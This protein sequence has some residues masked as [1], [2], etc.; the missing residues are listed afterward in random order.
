MQPESPLFFDPTR[1]TLYAYA[2]AQDQRCRNRDNCQRQLTSEGVAAALEWYQA[3]TVE[4]GVAL[5]ISTLATDEERQQAMLRPLSTDKSI[6]IWVDA[7]INHEYQLGLQP[8]GVLPFFPISAETP[9]LPSPLHQLFTIFA[10]HT[11]Q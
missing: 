6:A 4:S 9:L 11:K 10:Q 7:P 3:M 8:T 1:E 2:L 5:D